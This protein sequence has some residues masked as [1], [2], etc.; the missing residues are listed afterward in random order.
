MSCLQ[1][2]HLCPPGPPTLPII[3]NVH[4]FPRSHVAEAFSAWA[5]QYGD[6]FSLKLMNHT[7]IVLNTPSIVR[8]VFTKHAITNTNRP[9]STIAEMISPNGLNLGTSHYAGESWKIM[10]KASQHLLRGGKVKALNE[11]LHGEATQMVVDLMNKPENFME[12]SERFTTSNFL[13]IMYG[14]RGPQARSQDIHDF[15]YVNQRFMAALDMLAAPPVDVFPILKYVPGR[16]ATWKQDAV[17]IHHLHD[18]LYK[19]LLKKVKDRMA[20]GQANG[21]LMEQAIQSA[22]EWGLKDDDWLSNLGGTLLEGSHTTSGAVQSFI[23]TA[24]VHSEQQAIA[25]AE[26]EAVVGPDRVPMLSDLENLPYTCAFM[27]ESQRLYPVAPIG[28]PHEMTEDTIINGFLYPKDAI[29]FQNSWHIDRDERYFERPEEFLPERFLASVH[30]T[31]PG[32]ED[33]P[34]RTVNLRFGAGKRVCP[35]SAI[36]RTTLDT[37]GPYLLWAF[38]FKPALDPITGAEVPP[39]INFKS[40]SHAQGIAAPPLPFQCS[41]KLRSEHRRGVI[42]REFAQ[43]GHLLSRYELEIS[44]EDARYNKEHRDAA[45]EN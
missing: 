13:I 2:R 40:T 32:I 45:L 35:G 25:A 4:Q 36:A 11:I 27:K 21:C 33:D 41:I 34:A 9:A 18:S 29:L 24:A 22:R 8:E 10:R 37:I 23:L 1:R 17:E 28:L 31:K 14:T 16:F 44:D 30:G 5:R 19:R 42:Q 38:Q 39:E 6:V 12:H 15:T 7:V 20:K 3:G 43:A 26:L